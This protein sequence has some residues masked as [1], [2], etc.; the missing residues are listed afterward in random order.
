MRWI[1]FGAST[2]DDTGATMSLTQPYEI[3]MGSNTQ[4]TQVDLLGYD[5][6]EFTVEGLRTMCKQWGLRRD[7]TKGVLIRRIADEIE[8][9]SL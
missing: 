3:P 7:G 8:R 6:D 2:S 4:A 9:R 1:G 5:L